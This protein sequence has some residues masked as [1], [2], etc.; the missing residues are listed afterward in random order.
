MVLFGLR[1]LIR[2]EQA[3]QLLAWSTRQQW[4]LD[5]LPDLALWERGKP[6]F[7]HLPH[8]QFNLSHS[9]TLALCALSDRPVGVDI[10]MVRPVWRDSLIDRSCTLEERT[11]L[12]SRQDRPE[13]FAAL[14][15]A[16]ECLGKQN[17][18]GLPYPPARIAVPLPTLGAPFDPH[19]IYLSQG[20][21]LRF[22]F[23]DGWVGAACGL[24]LPPL[25]IVWTDTK[26][27]NE[28]R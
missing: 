17:G 23:G 2:R 27:L 13:E 6:Y 14:W 20:R 26:T 9:G 8:C 12:R 4:G 10:Q 5:P 1:G 21:F 28:N 11:W 3:R 16:K 7:P 19:E 24:E 15:A 22:Y 25:D 18:D